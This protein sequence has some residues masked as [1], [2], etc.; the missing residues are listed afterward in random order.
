[1]ATTM[2]VVMVAAA[3]AVGVSFGLT[4][5]EAKLDFS[6]LLK[7]NIEAL[8]KG[9]MNE[10]KWEVIPRDFG[11]VCVGGGNECCNPNGECYD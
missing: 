6:S 2:G 8:A 5:Q 7:Q 1:M 9:E 3:I 4:Q 10:R 11:F